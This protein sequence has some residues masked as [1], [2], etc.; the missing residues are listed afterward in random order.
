MRFDP[1]AHRALRAPRHHARRLAGHRGAP[2]LAVTAVLA[3]GAV[4]AACGGRDPFAPDPAR[5]ADTQQADLTVYPLSLA[6]GPLGSGVDVGSLRVVRPGVIVTSNVA[7]PT[8]DFAVDRG[9]GGRVR[10][11]PAPLLVSTGDAGAGLRTGF[12]ITATPFDSVGD[13]PQRGYQSDSATTVAPGQTV[14]VESQALACL[15]NRFNRTLYAKLV[16]LAVDSATGAVTLRA[17]VNPNC[18]FRSLRPGRG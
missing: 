1:A 4:A 3:L 10:L 6:V 2:L 5:N 11:L 12:Q 16:V 7:V 18:G 15:T 8:F 14:L 17:R 13:A 9:A